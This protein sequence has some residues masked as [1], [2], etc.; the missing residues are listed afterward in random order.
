MHFKKNVISAPK[1]FFNAIC[2]V[3]VAKALVEL[4]LLKRKLGPF[5]II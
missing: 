1:I 4:M 5:P 2:V 3:I